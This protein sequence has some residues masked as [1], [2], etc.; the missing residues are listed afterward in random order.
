MVKIHYRADFLNLPYHHAQA[1]ILSQVHH[2][3]NYGWVEGTIKISDC[4]K[5]ITLYLDFGDEEQYANSMHKINTMISHLSELRAN[6]HMN[7]E[8]LLNLK[9]K[10]RE[11][12]EAN[13]DKSDNLTDLEDLL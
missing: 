1:N 9:E 5:T 4:D 6:I 7:K 2:S 11:Y 12:K 10:R 13:K 8:N 3:S